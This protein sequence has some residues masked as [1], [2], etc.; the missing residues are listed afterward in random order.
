M[1]YIKG[2]EEKNVQNGRQNVNR[3]N[4][5]KFTYKSIHTFRLI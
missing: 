1:D 3:A 5:R 2:C 4:A